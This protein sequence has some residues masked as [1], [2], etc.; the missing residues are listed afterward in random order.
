MYDIMVNQQGVGEQEML[1]IL[2]Q[3]SRDN[4]RTPMQWNNSRYAGFSGAQPWLEVAVNYPEIN[5]EAAVADDNSVFHFY[6]KLIALRKEVEVI[7]TGDYRDLMPEHDS[8]FCYKRES[9]SQI[10]LCLNNYY[11]E[12]VECFMPKEIAVDKGTYILGNYAGVEGQQPS[13]CFIM[14]PYETRILLINK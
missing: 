10:L 2:A 13:H 3:K 7:T 6:R 5:A 11:G 8:L 4:S 9:E 14:Q 1:A 12:A